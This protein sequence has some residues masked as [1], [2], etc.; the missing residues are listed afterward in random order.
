MNRFRSPSYCTPSESSDLSSDEAG[1]QRDS[2]GATVRRPSAVD[3]QEI[4]RRLRKLA[5]RDDSTFADVWQDYATKY[6]REEWERLTRR[7]H[8]WM[9]ELLREIWPSRR[10]TGEFLWHPSER[11]RPNSIFQPRWDLPPRQRDSQEVEAD[12]LCLTLKE[13]WDLRPDDKDVRDL[14][15][16]RGNREEAAAESMRV[17]RH[18]I[19]EATYDCLKHFKSILGPR[20]IAE[21]RWFLAK[22]PASALLFDCLGRIER[23]HWLVSMNFTTVDGPDGA[24][25]ARALRQRPCVAIPPGSP[26][27]QLEALNNPPGMLYGIAEAIWQ[28]RLN[29]GILLGPYNVMEAA[30]A[31]TTE[32]AEALKFITMRKEEQL[33]WLK[34]QCIYWDENE[35]ELWE[36]E[37]DQE[38]EGSASLDKPEAPGASEGPSS[39]GENG[40]RPASDAGL[41]ADA[42]GSKRA[43]V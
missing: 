41:D 23:K 6:G 27:E 33:E 39:T 35:E 37:E 17:L 20:G 26:A 22:R 40:K 15:H 28:C 30:E 7:G 10:A 32:P 21:A 9:T 43:R 12:S 11:R 4:Q 18:R 34:E 24:A 16:P 29:H 38:P 14:L 2:E 13:Y 36:E 31:F 42:S 19:K 1:T 5:K 25:K 8:A 3:A